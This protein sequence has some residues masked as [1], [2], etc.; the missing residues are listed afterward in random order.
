MEQISIPSTGRYP[1]QNIVKQ[2]HGL[3]R[4]TRLC[5]QNELESFFL[6]IS[7][8]IMETVITCTKAEAKR[9][10]C[11][12][13]NKMSAEA[14]FL[15]FLGLFIVQG[16][17]FLG[18]FIVQGVLC[19]RKPV[20]A[21]WP[22]KYGRNL[23]RSMPLNRFSEIQRFLRFDDRTQRSWPGQVLSDLRCVG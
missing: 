8:I 15:A 10:K 16:I 2:A 11:A 1:Q 21:L 4:R 14:E 23:F 12:E 13:Y 20:G 3:T 17:L 7:P 19:A 5:A 9:V 6:M 18:L 22:A